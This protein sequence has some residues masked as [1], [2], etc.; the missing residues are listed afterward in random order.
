MYELLPMDP[1]FGEQD[2]SQTLNCNNLQAFTGFS[3][4]SPCIAREP[5]T[6]GWAVQLSEDH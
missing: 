6:A 3:C 1:D 2:R 4:D 5:K